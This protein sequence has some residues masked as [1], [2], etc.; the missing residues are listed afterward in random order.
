MIKI[1]TGDDRA[2]A[3]REI[4]RVLGDGYEVI[5]CTDLTPGDLPSI[6]KGTTI[7]DAHRRI[8]LRDFTANSS[9]FGE[10]SKYL[11]TP[12]DVILFE[13]KLD[14]RTTVYKDIKDK[15]EI[16]EFK[17][18]IKAN[19]NEV[20]DIFRVAKRDGEKAVAMLKKIEPT[21]EPIRFTGLLISQALKDFQ[22]NQGTKETKILKHLAKLDL[23]LKTTSIN[24]W[25][26]IEAFLLTV[27]SLG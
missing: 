19:F 4:K 5:D 3:N 15:V 2:A 7:F 18:Q 14:K 17:P 27:S 24:S 20:F 8:L 1:F 21:E 16:R 26:L 23:R 6:F 22:R 12:H 9:I 25:S 13:T 10:L 11:D